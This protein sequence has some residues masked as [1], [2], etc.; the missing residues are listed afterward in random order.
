MQQLFGL[1]NPVL[2][3]EVKKILIENDIDDLR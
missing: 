1:M 2:A 3:Y